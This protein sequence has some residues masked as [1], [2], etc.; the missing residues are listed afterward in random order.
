[1]IFDTFST[2]F[3][4]GLSG[5]YSEAY[6]AEVFQ[7]EWH[8][9]LREQDALS[10]IIIHPHL[11]IS[12]ENDQLS[13]KLIADSVGSSTK[14]ATD[15]VCRFQS[16][17]IAIGLF[18]LNSEGTEVIVNRILAAI[19]PQLSELLPNIDISI[20]ALNVHPS[21]AINIADVFER[22]EELADLAELKGKNAYEIDYLH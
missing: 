5:L 19:E 20:G 12:N 22:A 21:N 3:K 14:R 11:N 1:M 7:R 10:V 17:E 13:F 15:I 18:N 8:R 16:N 9:M 4:D 2:S 6:F